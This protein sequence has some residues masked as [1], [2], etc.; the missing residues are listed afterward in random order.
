MAKQTFRPSDLRD[1]T[2]FAVGPV[3]EGR[4][5]PA[6]DYLLTG[7]PSRPAPPEA[8]GG[9][10]RYDGGKKGPQ[11]RSVNRDGKGR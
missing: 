1:S 5:A 4:R 6:G 3:V 9:R 11:R 2:V 7:S 8:P 10:Q